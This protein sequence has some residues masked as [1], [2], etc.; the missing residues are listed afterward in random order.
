MKSAATPAFVLAR[1]C[2]VDGA[3]VAACVQS[4]DL[5]EDSEGE[6]HYELISPERDNIR[7]A[8]SWAIDTG[9]TPLDFYF[10]KWAGKAAR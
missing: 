7:A 6:Q 10:V 8:L 2:P 9:T 5:R 3:C 1:V 4:A